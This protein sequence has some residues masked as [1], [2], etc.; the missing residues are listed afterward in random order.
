MQKMNIT[1]PQT[2]A[3]DFP[4]SSQP[5]PFAPPIPQSLPFPA[6]PAQGPPVKGFGIKLLTECQRR[7]LRCPLYQYFHDK[8]T[9]QYQ[10][11]LKLSFLNEPIFGQPALTKLEATE[12]V[13]EIGLQKLAAHNQPIAFPAPPM[14]W[15]MPRPSQQQQSPPKHQPPPPQGAFGHPRMPQ[16]QVPQQYVTQQQ[17]QQLQQQ[18]QQ[19]QQQNVQQQPGPMHAAQPRHKQAAQPAPRIPG[20]SATRPSVPFVPL[21][22]V[23]Q[24]RI[25]RN[26]NSSQQSAKKNSHGR[27]SDENRS[28]A[29]QGQVA[30]QEKSSRNSK[31]ESDAR[32]SKEKEG[33][34][35]KPRRE[36]KIRIAANFSV[37]P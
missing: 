2:A 36:R 16:P 9:Q 13:A 32:D 6:A 30:G 15:C 25:H 26:S 17:F 27:K 1:A 8:T 21:Q 28:G 12:N 10:V 24:Q 19:P 18:L 11:Q 33:N 35:G 3:M 14:Q 29:Q 4:V 34:A 7:G 5:T 31:H 23:K 22:A 37:P 20:L